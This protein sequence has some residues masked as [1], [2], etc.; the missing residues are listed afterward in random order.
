MSEVFFSPMQSE[1]SG[2]LQTRSSNSVLQRVK[3]DMSPD[4]QDFQPLL[5]QISHQMAD[6]S[7]PYRCFLAGL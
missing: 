6:F 1:W 3:A 4:P 7:A 5:A 2:A